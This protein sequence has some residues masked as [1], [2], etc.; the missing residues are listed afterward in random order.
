MRRWTRRRP[1]KV[2]RNGNTYCPS[3]HEN[4][5][6]GSQS[7]LFG[8][9]IKDCLIV[10]KVNRAST[11]FW[12]SDVNGNKS[13]DGFYSSRD[14]DRDPTVPTQT[15]SR[16][17]GTDGLVRG[18]TIPVRSG[19][20]RDPSVGYVTL[21]KWYWVKQGTQQNNLK[22]DY[23]QLIIIHGRHKVYTGFVK[24]IMFPQES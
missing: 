7:P 2:S 9:S 18:R 11:I 13:E 19:E 21:L 20:S 12:R 5:P 14:Y 8:N 15:R 17:E 16:P 6:S 23:L 1:V 3:P 4:V 10:S 22:Y 24:H